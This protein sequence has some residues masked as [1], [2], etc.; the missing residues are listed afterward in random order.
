MSLGGVDIMKKL[1]F[2]FVIA[3]SLSARTGAAEVE[4]DGESFKVIDTHL[5]FGE[6]GQMALKGKKFTIGAMPGFVK[7]YAPGVMAQGVRP[8]AKHLGIA[9][10][11][12]MAGVDHGIL[13]AV[14]THH[15]TGYATNAALAAWLAD[16]RNVADDGR[17]IFWGLVSINFDD[18]DTPNLAS[19]RLE[20]MRS[21]LV[22]YPELIVGIKLAH[23]HQNV[24]FDDELYHGVYGVAAET[25]VP[26]LLHTGFSPFPGSSD[27]AHYYDTAYLEDVVAGYD[28][29]DGRPLVNF[30]FAHTG[31][32]DKRS[33]DSALRMAR[34]YPNVYLDLSALK[35][36][37]LLDEK[38]E[39]LSAEDQ[40]KAH[41]ASQLPYVVQ[42]IKE[43]EIVHK[44]L[45]S[46]DGPQYSGMV[47]SYLNHC[48]TI[49]K[50]AGFTGEELRAVLS[51]NGAKVFGLE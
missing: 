7:L 1:I 30:V 13:L 15:T 28:G 22:D 3:C 48:L 5:H 35:G 18:F 31:Q 10:Q 24:P 43:Y 4:V 8:Y 17:P 23:A 44:A 36:P 14:Y 19:E 42:K 45:W 39:E 33:V 38:G 27:D 50:E 51:E 37:F 11:L 6:F 26:V 20:A 34:D 21:Y 41:N 9:S 40:E 47:K 16:P 29:Q 2:L 46:T 32:G 49:F 25:G 12:E